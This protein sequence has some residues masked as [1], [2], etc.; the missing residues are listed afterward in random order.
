M[1]NRRA[2]SSRSSCDTPIPCVMARVI[3]SNLWPAPEG[4][5]AQAGVPAGLSAE[6]AQ[7]LLQQFGAVD[8]QRAA[9]QPGEADAP[10]EAP[11]QTPPA[12]A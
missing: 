12:Q 10:A 9:R 7:A 1:G 2:N 11:Q 3:D 4:S 5:N 6:Q 8:L